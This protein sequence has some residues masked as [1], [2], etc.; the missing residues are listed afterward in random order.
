MSK[1]SSSQSHTKSEKT[2]ERSMLND[3]QES[4]LFDSDT[5]VKFKTLFKNEDGQ[6]PVQTLI[7]DAKEQLDVLLSLN[8]LDPSLIKSIKRNLINSTNS[9]LEINVSWSDMINEYKRLEKS[10]S[11][12]NVD[13]LAQD[14]YLRLDAFLSVLQGEISE[15]INNIGPVINFLL[16]KKFNRS[17]EEIEVL[18]SR[19]INATKDIEEKNILAT[20]LVNNMAMLPTKQQIASFSQI[21]GDE[22]ESFRSSSKGWIAGVFACLIGVVGASVYY[23]WLVTDEEFSKFSV[24]QIIQFNLTKILTISA[25]FYGLA[26]CNKN[27]KSSKHNQ[28]LN[29]HRANAL[30]SFQAFV[31]SPN[32]DATTKNAVLL[33]ATKTIYGVQQTGYV[34]T[35]NDDSP[36]K[37]IEMIQ[38]VQPK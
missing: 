13:K 36:N 38:S 14:F 24:N 34:Q 12:L 26:I 3:L 11:L 4:I 33:E 10:G 32:A 19:A 5:L 7:F 1:T 15:F 37:I 27:Y 35:D 29:K 8:P 31:E 21:F 9:L 23:S 6:Y 22:S 30:A 17:K 16:I 2:V 20:E 25:L 28:I 18:E